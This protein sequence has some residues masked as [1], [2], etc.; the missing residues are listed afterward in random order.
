M[1]FGRSQSAFSEICNLAM[2]CF[3]TNTFPRKCAVLKAHEISLL[4]TRSSLDV[5]ILSAEEEIRRILGNAN[6]SSKHLPPDD[7]VQDMLISA[8]ET[9]TPP[10]LEKEQ[11]IPDLLQDIKDIKDGGE[12][13]SADKKSQSSS[14]GTRSSNSTA[15]T[16][17]SCDILRESM[18]VTIENSALCE[19]YT[20][21][22]GE[23]CPWCVIDK[24]RACFV[25][26]YF[27]IMN[28]ARIRVILSSTRKCRWRTWLAYVVTLKCEFFKYF[29]SLIKN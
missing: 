28:F 15:A 5:I 23:S 24:C 14:T 8:K 9:D 6:D 17:S 11:N 13:L 10:L 4:N 27:P 3:E 21:V 2:L 1:F 12:T 22:E 16:S 26:R 19:N 18:D 25:L 20:L 29:R 7:G